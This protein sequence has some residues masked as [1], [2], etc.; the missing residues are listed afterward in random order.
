MDYCGEKG[1]DLRFT[2]RIYVGFAS[3][4]L[5]LFCACNSSELHELARKKGITYCFIFPVFLLARMD[6][7]LKFTFDYLY[8]H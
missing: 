6:F 1:C 8:D 3:M 7:F 2:E 4:D 5:S